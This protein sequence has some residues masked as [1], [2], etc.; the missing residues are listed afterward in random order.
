MDCK[1]RYSDTIFTIPGQFPG[2]YIEPIH[3]VFYTKSEELIALSKQWYQGRMNETEARLYFLALMNSTGLIDWQCSARPSTRIITTNMEPMIKMVN[4]HHTVISP[5]FKFPKLAVGWDNRDL[6]NIYHWID[7]IQDIKENWKINYRQSQVRA[8]LEQQELALNKMLH[9]YMRNVNTYTTRLAEWAITAVSPAHPTQNELDQFTR[10]R[11]LF[12]LTGLEIHRVD[13]LDLEDM[14]EYF[15]VHLDFAHDQVFGQEVM[16]HIRKLLEINSKGIDYAIGLPDDFALED[17]EL[18]VAAKGSNFTILPDDA[19]PFSSGTREE[20][21]EAY[22]K[23]AAAQTAPIIK[24]IRTN[25]ASTVE[26]L[27]DMAKWNIAKKAGMVTEVSF[28]D[29]FSGLY[30]NGAQ[31]GST[32]K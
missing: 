9:S 24:P 22:N 14:L 32:E 7:S 17:F 2:L 1:C 20:S 25:Y 4:W 15:E 18:A 27:Q 28:K 11:E 26:F 6:Q 30:N 12:T 13:R 8:K 10:F 21:V 3:P 29:R 16:K 23:L 19:D 5:Q 31:S